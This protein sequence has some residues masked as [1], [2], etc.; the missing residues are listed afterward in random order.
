MIRLSIIV[1]ATAKNGIG[2][3]GTMPW[4]IHDDL[5]Y[6]AHV[7]QNAPEGT[8]NAVI[9]GRKTWES[10]PAKNRPLS[11]RLNIVISN[12]DSYN[13]FVHLYTF[14]RPGTAVLVKSLEQALHVSSDVPINRGFIVGGAS[15]YQKTLIPTPEAEVDRVLVTRITAPE[16]DCDTFM[17][18]FTTYGKW[19]R[20]SHQ[21]LVDWVGFPVAEGAQ[22]QAD[23]TEYEFQMW[24]RVE[25]QAK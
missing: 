7:T 6:F 8:Q 3:G 17:P 25:E 4:H 24:T 1:A 9:M 11:K 16:F 19:V 10:I 2:K 12:D 5:R 14:I 22:K 20:A 23:G 15:L 13:L 21:A 18:D